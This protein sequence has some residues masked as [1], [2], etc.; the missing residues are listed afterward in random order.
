MSKHLCKAS[1]WEWH[2]VII[3]LIAIAF[4]IITINAVIKKKVTSLVIFCLGLLFCL[5]QLNETA[6][7]YCDRKPYTK[8][9]ILEKFS[10]WSGSGEYNF[11]YTPCGCSEKWE[12]IYPYSIQ[13]WFYF[14]S[15]N[16]MSFLMLISA[17]LRHYPRQVIA[18]ALLQMWLPDSFSY[19][20][21]CL[22]FFDFWG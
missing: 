16:K 10:A 2:I 22:H 5:V 4:I 13:L 14:F 11:L 18:A 12:R 15:K 3:Q 20:N 9:R 19:L 1:R 8:P 6:C 7:T 21:S 17:T